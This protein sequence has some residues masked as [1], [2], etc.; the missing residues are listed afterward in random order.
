MTDERE[1]VVTSFNVPKEYVE[2]WRAES[3]N[4]SELV[5]NLL[6]EYYRGGRAA[7]VE[8]AVRRMRVNQIETEI[9]MHED[10]RDRL[11]SEL[12]TL[13][14]SLD[15]DD[16][17]YFGELDAILDAMEGRMKVD[18]DLPR[19][20]KLAAKR[21]GASDYGGEVLADLR[22]QA[23]EQGRDIDDDHWP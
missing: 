14:D 15:A 16:G 23:A 20:K 7:G 13:T 12:S 18:A 22:E 17:H 5:T 4:R 3:T 9:Q 2:R 6:D 1:R 21:Y 8:D 10:Q 19:I 11:E